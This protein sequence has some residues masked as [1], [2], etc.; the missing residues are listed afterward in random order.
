[1]QLQAT[2]QPSSPC[3]A[4]SDIRS[5]TDVACSLQRS[6][7]LVIASGFS[8]KAGNVWCVRE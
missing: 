7:L 3:H 8:L 2:L 4:V 5:V 1:M 6:Y